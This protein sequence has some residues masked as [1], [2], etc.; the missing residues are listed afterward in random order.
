[1]TQQMTL[2]QEYLAE[3]FIMALF[4]LDPQEKN[5]VAHLAQLRRQGLPFVRLSRKVRVY[6]R[7]ELAAYFSAR[8]M[9]GV[10]E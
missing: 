7:A 4:G 1:M 2:D 8:K 3:S 9:Q 5:D 10:D 6:P